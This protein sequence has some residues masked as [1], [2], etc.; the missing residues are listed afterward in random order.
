MNKIKNIK[1][2]SN[3][4]LDTTQQLSGQLAQ[5]L[6]PLIFHRRDSL[7][8]RKKLFNLYYYFYSI[9]ISLAQDEHSN[10]WD[11]SYHH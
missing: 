6:K 4:S 7:E 1:F 11:P 8:H 2:L 10:D 9:I 5:Q 3:F